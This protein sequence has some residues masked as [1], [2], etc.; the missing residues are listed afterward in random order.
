[1]FLNTIMIDAD[2]RN[3]LY[4][5]VRD[6]LSGVGDLWTTLED[7]KDYATAERLASEFGGEFRLMADLG[8]DPDDD[9][10]TVELT[11][12]PLD[13]IEVAT[14]L[15]ENAKGGL[16]DV[17]EEREAV[18]PPPL[19]E[20]YKLTLKTCEEILTALT[21]TPGGGRHVCA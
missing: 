20:H 10:E 19:I 5:Q 17:E 12:A 8:W 21:D 14:R 2:Q 4:E 1:M 11:M 3:A 9:R 18:A 7:K 15:S 16:A 6:H 13:L